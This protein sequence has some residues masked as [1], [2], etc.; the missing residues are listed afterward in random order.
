MNDSVDYI[1]DFF[2]GINEFAKTDVNEE[3]S[4][5]VNESLP[6]DT[7][8]ADVPLVQPRVTYKGVERPVSIASSNW[9]I[10]FLTLFF[11][12]ICIAMNNQFRY[13]KVNLNAL[14]S[15]HES[16]MMPS[17]TLNFGWP[18]HIFLSL[19]TVM[20]YGVFLSFVNL[21]YNGT[22]SFD[23]GCLWF[24]LAFFIYF[25]FSYI[26]I[27]FV[28]FIF[29]DKVATTIASRFYYI[30]V[31]YGS[32]LLFPSVLGM[33]FAP[34]YLFNVFMYLGFGAIILVFLIE[35][36]Q[37]IRIFFSGIGHLFYIILYFCT[38]KFL[39]IAVL[40][41]IVFSTII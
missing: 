40:A 28:G 20:C 21:R 5:L 25:L 16:D 41:K 24:S 15:S 31:E 14:F 1:P 27:W 7:L 39:L 3:F 32:I 8:V 9:L 11:L 38:L 12:S 35:I 10:F 33:I 34:A 26:S 6:S 4:L 18:A 23:T 2:I 29:W 19:M 37:S 13:I 30:L 17:K 36:F 22:P